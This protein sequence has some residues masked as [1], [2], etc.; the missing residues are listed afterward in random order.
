MSGY[1][2]KMIA[3]ALNKPSNK[4]IF[5]NNFSVF[6]EISEGNKNL[7]IEFT[8]PSIYFLSSKFYTI[9]INLLFKINILCHSHP[10]KSCLYLTDIIFD[11]MSLNQ[12][13]M[14]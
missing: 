8:I 4:A 10:M 13:G 12:V 6:R 11:Y 9:I 3:T 2:S 14:S 1:Q 7:K 5:F